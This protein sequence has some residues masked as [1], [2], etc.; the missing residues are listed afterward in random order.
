MLNPNKAEFESETLYR[1][2][3]NRLRDLIYKERKAS[4]PVYYLIK[5]IFNIII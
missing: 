1:I 3:T 2:R 5:I 4:Q